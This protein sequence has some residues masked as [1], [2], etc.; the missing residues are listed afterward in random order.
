M[1]DLA[2]LIWI[3]FILLMITTYCKHGKIMEYFILPT[4]LLCGS[5]VVQS[6][7]KGLILIY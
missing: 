1:L 7:K 6:M 4:V 5:I 3:E 2:S